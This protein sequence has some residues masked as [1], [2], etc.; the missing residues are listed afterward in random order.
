[1]YKLK[2]Y[3]RKRKQLKIVNISKIKNSFSH[4]IIFINIDYQKLLKKYLL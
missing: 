1:M 4:I 2:K 3:M